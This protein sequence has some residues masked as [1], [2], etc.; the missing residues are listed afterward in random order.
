[1]SKAIENVLKSY[2]QSRGYDKEA[3]LSL[4][5]HAQM[6]EEMLKSMIQEWSKGCSCSSPGHPEECHECTVALIHSIDTVL[7]GR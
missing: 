6:M 4:I 1:M 5:D 2:N 7:S 3:V